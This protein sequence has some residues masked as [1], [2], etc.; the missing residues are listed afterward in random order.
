MV[1]MKPLAPA[2]G[3][4]RESDAQ[5]RVDA[6]VMFAVWACTQ[7]AFPAQSAIAAE[8]GVS[9]RTASRWRKSLARAVA[10][11]ASLPEEG[12]ALRQVPPRADSK[13]IG[14]EIARHP[15]LLALTP[16]ALVKSIRERYP[17][18]DP[19]A[20]RAIAHALT[21]LMQSPTP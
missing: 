2:L 9:L 13:A 18:S 14:A 15:A 12:R 4:Q 21:L 3:Q 11:A 16:S 19:T 5:R 20:R 10:A 1:P 7:P 6:A 17:C 8:F